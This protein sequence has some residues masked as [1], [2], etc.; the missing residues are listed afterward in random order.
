[1]PEDIGVIQLEWRAPRPEIAGM[2]QHN[3]VTG[4]SW[5]VR[6]E[7][8]PDGGGAAITIPADKVTSPD[9]GD[10]KR[11]QER[12]PPRMDIAPAFS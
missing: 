8:T 5:F 7:Y 9:A 6:A 3:L 1:M 4:E 12:L 10:D 11:G 2:N